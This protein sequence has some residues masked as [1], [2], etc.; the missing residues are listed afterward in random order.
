MSYDTKSLERELEEARG[1]LTDHLSEAQEKVRDAVDWRAHYRRDPWPF[2]AGAAVVGLG[3]SALLRRR[4]SSQRWAD[5]EPAGVPLPQRLAATPVGTRT[6]Q[7]LEQLADVLI[8]VG[9]AKVAQYVDAW[10]P[11]FHDEF[12]RR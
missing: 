1:A 5:E 4:P 3:A 6:G 8:A 7:A 12:R 11:G 10:L 9:T 2:L